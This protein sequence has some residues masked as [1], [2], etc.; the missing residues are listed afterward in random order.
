MT[1]TKS[2]HRSRGPNSDIWFQLTW[3]EWVPCYLFSIIREI[4]NNLLTGK[5]TIC[6]QAFEKSIWNFC[7]CVFKCQILLSFG[8]LEVFTIDVYR[9]LL[10][11]EFWCDKEGAKHQLTAR[12]NGQNG[13]AKI[14][15]SSD[16]DLTI[17]KTILISWLR[18]WIV[19]V[20]PV[21]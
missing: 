7:R 17:M 10:T 6:F 3:E 14:I 20:P 11:A 21:F 12:E 4:L 16:F 5:L 18:G 9:F 8:I 15:W 13:N 1:Q 19:F 2:K